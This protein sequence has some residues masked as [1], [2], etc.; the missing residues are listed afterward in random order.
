MELTQLVCSRCE[1]DFI[2]VRDPETLGEKP[3]LCS[4]C[5]AKLTT[6][7]NNLERAQRHILDAEREREQEANAPLK[8]PLCEKMTL[9]HKEVGPTNLFVC[10]ECPFVGMEYYG[11]ENRCDLATYLTRETWMFCCDNKDCGNNFHGDFTTKKCPK[12]WGTD[13]THVV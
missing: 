1:C 6:N 5:E 3:E 11:E 10:S 4:A 7:M 2:E 8:C 9:E 12:C 13:I